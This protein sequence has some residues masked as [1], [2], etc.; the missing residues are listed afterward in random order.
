[1]QKNLFTTYFKH[2]IETLPDMAW[3]KDSS[4]SYMYANNFTIK[5]F[6]YNS[7]DDL[8]GKKN[9]NINCF[10]NSYIAT[11]KIDEILMLLLNIPLNT[12]DVIKLN[13]KQTTYCLTNKYPIY[14]EDK[15][16]I[17]IFCTAKILNNSEILLNLMPHLLEKNI[18]TLIPGSYFIEQDEKNLGSLIRSIPNAQNKAEII[19]TIY[20]LKGTQSLSEIPS[21]KIKLISD[22]KQLRQ[23]AQN[24][25]TNN[26]AKQ[27]D[28][29]LV[30]LKSQ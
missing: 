25:Y 20:S 13:N 8:F 6:G 16:N 21:E 15:Q 19:N 29:A 28:D 24:K 26:I 12:F 18:E 22:L 14:S 3:W 10:T 17:G 27:I 7:A 5:L 4:L 23:I 9:E 1:M 11:T 2:Y 30:K